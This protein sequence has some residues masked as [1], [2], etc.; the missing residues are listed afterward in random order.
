[1]QNKVQHQQQEIS[2]PFADSDKPI[3]WIDLEMTGL[4]PEK[5][6]ILEVGIVVTDSDLKNRIIGPN[7]II[8]CNEEILSRMDDWNMKHHT[9]SG[10]LDAVK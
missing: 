3:V 5:E 9:E 6:T 4:D 1:M 7:L 2:V 8:H 10:L